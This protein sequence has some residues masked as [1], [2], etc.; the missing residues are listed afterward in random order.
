MPR[1]VSAD[2]GNHAICRLQSLQD[3]GGLIT[4]LG[5]Y[6]LYYMPYVSFAVFILKW[7]N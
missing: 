3:S 1:G 4:S 5:C 6:T 2:G 7:Y